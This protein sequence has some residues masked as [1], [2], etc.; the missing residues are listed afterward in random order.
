MR[1]L[2]K[3]LLYVAFPLI[4]MI[5]LMIK[6]IEVCCFLDT[7]NSFLKSFKKGF[8]VWFSKRREAQLKRKSSTRFEV[9]IIT[10][11]ELPTTR[12]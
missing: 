8:T 4:S 7:R 10:P 5:F 3:N 6:F 9:I 11:K 1:K 12:K 2:I